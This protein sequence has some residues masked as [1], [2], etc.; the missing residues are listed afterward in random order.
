MQPGTLLCLQQSAEGEFS[1]N[2]PRGGNPSFQANVGP[3]N[4]GNLL[5]N[6]FLELN[7]S[8]FTSLVLE[9]PLI[10]STLTEIY[11]SRCDSC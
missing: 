1:T 11:V 10:S 5:F 4:W 8:R 6:R 9:R 7:A 3:L 2:R